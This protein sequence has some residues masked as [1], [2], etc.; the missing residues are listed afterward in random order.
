MYS[1][2]YS[3][4]RPGASLPG[5]YNGCAFGEEK[6]CENFEEP[7]TA[8]GCEAERENES[9]DEK[10][11]AKEACASPGSHGGFLSGLF[12]SVF[13][14]F[15]GGLNLKFPKIGVEEILIIATA[16][17]LL[18]SKEGDTE[19]AILLFLLLLIN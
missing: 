10:F 9:C 7:L 16:L 15:R 12:D 19:C 2:S 5:G 6:R 18:F 13:G 4:D 11:E 17:F 8:L 1:R 14:S 3:A